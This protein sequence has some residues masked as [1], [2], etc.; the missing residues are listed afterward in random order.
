MI[1]KRTTRVLLVLG[2]LALAALPARAQITTGTV[3]GTVK[4]PQGAVVPGATVVLISETKG[5]KS[6]P[7]I[8]NSTG[9]YVIPTV[10]ADTYTVEI[11]ME[12]FKTVQRKNVQVTGG[13]RVVVPIVT[14]EV[15]GAAET[16]NVQAESPMIQAQ[17]GERSF[18]V[19]TEQI[20][21]LPVAHQ[22]FTNFT[23]LT[24]G[25]VAGG[26]S[27]GGTRLGGAGQNNI[28]MDGVSAMDTGNNGQMLSMNI[29]S[30]AEVKILTQGY[31]AEYGR[32][33]GLQI[34]AVTK[35]GTNQFRGSAYDLQGNSSWNTNSWTNLKNGDPKV[36][37]TAKTLGYSIGGPIGKP[38]GNNKLFFF[39]AHEY[40]PATNYTNGGNPIRLRLPTQ[41]ER[42][43]DFSQ[44]L[45]N[46]GKPIPQLKDPNGN[47]YPGNMIPSSAWYSL[48]QTI[49]NRYPLPNVAQAPGTNYNYQIAAPSVKQLTQQPAVKIDYQYSPKLRF[50]GK[51][52][53]Q[54]ARR[55]TQPGN[56]PG[57]NDVYTPYPFITNYGATVNYVMTPTTF[58]EGTYGFIRNQLSGGAEGGILTND[59]SNRLN[60]L[61]AFPLVYPNAGA[62]NQQYYAYQVLQAVKPV[63]WDGTN[64]NLPPVFGWGSLIAGNSGTCALPNPQCQRFPGFLNINRTQDVAGSITKIWGHH[65]IKAGAYNNHSY[66]AQNTGAGGVANLSFQPFVD[67]GNSS[68]NPIDSGFGFSNALTGVFTQYLQQSAFI[69]GS[70]LYNNTEGYVQDN[71]KVNSRLTLDYGVR[72]T[73]QQPQYDQFGQ[74]SNFFPNKWSPSAAPTLYV[75]GCSNGAPTCSGNNLNAMDPRNGSFI[76]PPSGNSQSLIG[77]PVPN[78]GSSTNGVLAAGHGISKYSYTWPAVVFGPRVGYAYDITGTQKYVVRGGAGWFYD[79]PDGNT[80]F[81]I[82]GNP[83]WTVGSVSPTS[84][85]ILNSTLASLGTGLSPLPVPTLVVFQ[86][87]AKVPTSVQ[88]QSELQVALPWS[89]AFTVAYVGNHGYNRLGAFQ[90]GSTVNLN[91]V[92]FGTAYQPQFQD[93]TKAPSATPGATALSGNLLRPYAGYNLINQNTTDFHDTYHSVQ[94]TLNRRYRNGYAFGFN[95]TRG[96]SFT[97]N[98][99]L[100]ERL[101]HNPDGSYSIRA[102][103]AQYEA[104]NHKLDLRPNVIKANAL[105][106]IPKLHGSDHGTMKVVGYVLNDW[107]VSGVL[108]AGSAAAYDL[109]FQYSALGTNTNITGSPDYA[110]RVVYTGNPGMGCSSNQY[111]QFNAAVVQGPAYHSVGLESGRNILRNCADHTVDM[112]VA[113]SIRLP[114]QK[115]IVFRADIFNLFNS[116]IINGRV[117][118]AVFNNPTSMTLTNSETLPDGSVDPN[119]TLPKNAG[120][121]AATSA[122]NN[123]GQAGLGNN[124]NRTIMLQVRFQF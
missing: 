28:Q 62:V 26:A 41:A 68:S 80:V 61:A 35:S 56:L 90:G 102:D 4:D 81:S 50:S 109:S 110:G 121:G 2:L 13:E 54:R 3:A 97:G 1:R 9:D 124:Y 75:P 77:T 115:N 64:I 37:A 25:V 74:M 49:L 72:L 118:N 5:T 24:P 87:N 113:K 76:I 57:F 88:W 15:G 32:S 94:F 44:S 39:Y 7:Q 66:K 6:N 95:Y 116:Y 89:S 83:G 23:S 100:Q 104:L 98:T 52:S 47:P 82:P 65:T 119:K 55:L 86:Y 91:A 123:G 20:Q 101:Q 92:D 46:N 60:G 59:S 96:I 63:W 16:V 93:P 111:A 40:R 79:R 12:G 27:A 112:A 14:L 21:N 11:S 71:W 10:T 30:I 17:S 122:Q 69:E 53:G 70:M 45:D 58:I 120:F 114:G 99:G 51:Y 18:A 8:T 33:S 105:Y 48:G 85:N 117:T 19:A 36:S 67:F 103:Q 38:G 34:T 78:S 29:E 107:Q 22:N 73:H 108:T 42:N 106:D 31:Q 43:G 84:T